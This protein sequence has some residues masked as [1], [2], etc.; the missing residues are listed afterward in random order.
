MGTIPKVIAVLAIL[1]VGGKIGQ[2]MM[3]NYD[4][5]E[6]VQQMVTDMDAQ[7]PKE[8]SPGMMLTRI[9]LDGD[10]LRN[11][12][13]IDKS[14]PFDS[15]RRSQYETNARTQV[16]E[17]MKAF[18]DNG[19]TVDFRYNYQASGVDELFDISVPPHM[20]V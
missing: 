5:N 8:V 11:H 16:C 4:V 9:E 17:G 6:Q 20:C 10:V 12:Y 18:P 1:F 3:S 13:T 2:K 15:A 19:I 7:L 14:V